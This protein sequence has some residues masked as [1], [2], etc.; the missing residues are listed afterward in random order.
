MWK[1]NRRRYS[2]KFA[3]LGPDPQVQQGL[4]ADLRR[5]RDDE[6]VR[7]PAARRQRRIQQRGGRRRVA[8]APHQRVPEVR[9]DQPRAAG[10][11]GLPAEHLG[12]P[13]ADEPAHVPAHPARARR[14]HAPARANDVARSAAA[15]ALWMRGCWRS[16]LGGCASLPFF[17]KD[18]DAE[19][20]SRGRAADRASTSSRSTRPSRLRQLLLDYLDLARFQNAP[21]SDAIT[22]AELDRLVA[23]RAGAGARAARD[24]GLLRRR[25]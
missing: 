10:R 14:S 16:L 21:A 20:A 19:P 17:G 11:L 5:R 22:P 9:L 12:D 13:A 23:R 15:R 1:N 7:D 3:H 4:Q 2:E 18:A 8:A 24:R 6:P 25:R